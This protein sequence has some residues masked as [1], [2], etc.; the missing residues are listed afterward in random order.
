MGSGKVSIVI[1]VFNEA[2]RLE[3]NVGVVD[4]YLAM[5]DMD[6]EI[7][8]VDDG[9]TDGTG[10]IGKGLEAT[11]PRIR[12]IGYPHNRGKGFAVRTGMLGAVGTRIVFMDADLA[13]PMPFVGSCLDRLQDRGSMV[14]GS[15]HIAGA[16]LKVR[17][18]WARETMGHVY[19][20]IARAVLRLHVTDI[21]CG[22]KGF[23]STAAKEI[24]SLSKV[25]RWGYDAEIIFLAQKLGFGIHEM[26]VDWYNSSDSKVI[27]G[28]DAVR[29][30]MEL[31]KILSTDLQGGY[32]R[33]V[34]RATKAP[35][36]WG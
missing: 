10:R 21:T 16:R 4:Q 12:T 14:I 17:Q 31:L 18:G 30:F 29:S 20:A 6:Y 1:P 36:I 19:R 2:R 27:I 23:S 26:P 11:L 28:L 3:Q 22:L 32:G 9:S 24:F 13:V 5:C 25:D 33:S 15:R 34:R 7:L 35:S 8:L